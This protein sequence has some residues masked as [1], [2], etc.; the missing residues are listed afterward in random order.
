MKNPKTPTVNFTLEE[1]ERLRKIQAGFEALSLLTENG[2][3]HDRSG[4]D[5]FEYPDKNTSH[6]LDSLRGDISER[7][8]L[9]E[10]QDAAG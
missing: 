7:E 5:G 8:K 3:G 2:T 10:K 6:D 4:G 1:F 9:N